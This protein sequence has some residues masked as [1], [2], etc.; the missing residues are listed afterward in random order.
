MEE[1]MSVSL[2]KDQK[3][4]KQVDQLHAMKEEQSNGLDKLPTVAANR[5]PNYK[6]RADEA[7]KYVFVRTV[8]KHLSTATKS[9]TEEVR[10]L[11]IHVNEFD[12]KIEE[13]YFELYDVVEV[14]HDPR[15]NAPKK[16]DL[17]LKKESGQIKTP[18]GG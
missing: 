16:Y 6:V 15:S 4:M 18:K 3:L 13:R 11:P 1:T 8:I 17:K 2:S 9:I 14:I 5:N 7:E 10:T 12:R